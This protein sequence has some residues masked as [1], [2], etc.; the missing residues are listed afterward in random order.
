MAKEASDDAKNPISGK[1]QKQENDKQKGDKELEEKLLDV[2][3]KRLQN[4]AESNKL[5]AEAKQLLA[6]AG[7]A[8]K[9]AKRVAK[10]L[11]VRSFHPSAYMALRMLLT[12]PVENYRGW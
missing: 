4:L 5:E 3:K 1:K 10:A 8:D 9:L 6:Q 7:D 12:F 2:E 11:K